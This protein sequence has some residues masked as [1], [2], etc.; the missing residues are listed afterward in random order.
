MLK[1]NSDGDSKRISKSARLNR[2]ASELRKNLFRRKQ[3]TR[4]RAAQQTTP[5][6][7]RDQ[8]ENDI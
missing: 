7:T 5:T 8:N 1:R 4:A 2:Q 3:Q 6:L